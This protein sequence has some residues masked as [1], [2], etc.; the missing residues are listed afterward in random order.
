[1]KKINDIQLYLYFSIIT[2]VIG[3]LL[4]LTFSYSAYIVEPEIEKLLE[5]QDNINDNFKN[6]YLKL[7][8][9][10]IFARYENYDSIS[11]PIESII[12]VFDKRIKEGEAFEINDKIYLHI[13]LER[14]KQGAQLT[15]NTFVFFYAISLLGLI[16]YFSERIQLKKNAS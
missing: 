9:P 1:M 5:N 10:Q 6:A 3:L 13:L 14:R 7:K 11:R 4:T 8:D 15:R 12:E 2:A 16:F